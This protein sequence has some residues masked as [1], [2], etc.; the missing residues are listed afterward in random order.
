MIE[1]GSGGADAA[2]F[3]PASSYGDGDGSLDIAAELSG[4]EAFNQSCVV[5]SRCGGRKDGFW[6]TESLMHDA[7]ADLEFMA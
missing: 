4:L 6:F 1:N 2:T 5:L 7:N 3:A